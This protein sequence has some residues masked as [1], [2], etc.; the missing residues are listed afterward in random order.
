VG[1]RADI[2]TGDAA[3]LPTARVAADIVFI[4]PPYHQ[5]LG[6]AALASAQAVGWLAPDAL[7]IIQHHPKEALELPPGF[8]QTDSRRYGANQLTF[9]ERE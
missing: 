5:G 1:E 4:D 8:Q 2:I 9:I 3:K 6:V 7:V